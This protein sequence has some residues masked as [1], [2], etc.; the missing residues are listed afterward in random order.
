MNQHLTIKD[1]P[2]S[3]KPYEKFLKYGPESLSDA[4]LLAVIIKSGTNGLKSVEV[5]QNFL[6]QKNRNLMNLYDVSYEEMQRMKG[7]G[8]VKAIQLKCIAELS[9]RITA[10]RYIQLISLKDARSIATY[11]ME[12]LRHET[13]ELL[14]LCM[15]DSKC[16]LIADEVI[17]KGSVNSSI[18]PPREIFMLALRKCAVHIV[19]LH[20]HPS[21]VSAPSREDN[22][23]T[24]RIAEC[25]QMIGIP[26]SDHI[27]IGDQNYFSYRESGLL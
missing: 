10:T 11:F 13:Q 9:N 17:S 16:R 2:D 18:V 5:A 12:K 8:K 15:F 21:G 25:G 14:V 24:Q 22:E 23:V 19:L 3:E 4:E 6:N 1:L 7:I 27:I 20:N 26:L